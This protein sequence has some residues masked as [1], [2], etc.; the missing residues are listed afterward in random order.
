LHTSSSGQAGDKLIVG[1]R[2]S[3]LRAKFDP[4]A[5]CRSSWL[6]VKFATRDL[7]GAFERHP[8]LL[9]SGGGFSA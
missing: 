7:I 8:L 4:R 2:G 1:R 5:L 3:R 9:F 6:H